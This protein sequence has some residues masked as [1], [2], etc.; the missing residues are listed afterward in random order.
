MYLKVQLLP[1]PKTTSKSKYRTFDLKSVTFDP[2]YPQK[3]Q[4]D[5]PQVRP[6]TVEKSKSRKSWKVVQ[7][8]KMKFD[9]NV[10]FLGEG[11]PED[12]KNI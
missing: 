5:T 8:E 7:Y 1:H 12:R 9:K 2:K 3:G 11:R 4:K 6:K 10:Y